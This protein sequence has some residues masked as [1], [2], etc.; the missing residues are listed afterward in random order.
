MSCPKDKH[1]N[2]WQAF[3]RILSEFPKDVF[4]EL[5]TDLAENHDKYL[6]DKDKIENPHLMQ[7]K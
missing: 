4:A 1:E 3:K 5:P 6:Y 2:I 7:R